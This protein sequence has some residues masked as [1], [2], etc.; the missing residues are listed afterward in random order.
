K[1]T[2]GYPSFM[3][4]DTPS[5]EVCTAR[6]IVTNTPLQALAALNDEAH[7]E[8]AQ[9]LGKRMQKEAGPE[10][11]SEIAWAY[12]LVTN[13]EASPDTVA[14]LAALYREAVAKYEQDP[15][16]SAAMGGE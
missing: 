2:S 8:F 4:F 14:D 11:E 6:R 7:I 3:A 15:A 10:I 12:A 5:R 9:A 16:K 13:H 1:R